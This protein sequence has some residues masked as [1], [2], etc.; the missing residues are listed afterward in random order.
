MYVSWSVFFC[1]FS[2]E[3][4]YLCLTILSLIVPVYPVNMPDLAWTRPVMAI[5]ASGQPESGRIRFAESDFP[6]PI[7]IRT[8][9]FF[10]H[11][12]WPGSSLSDP[13]L[14]IS[15]RSDIVA[16]NW[17]KPDPTCLRRNRPGPHPACL[18]WA[19]YSSIDP[20]RIRF[21]TSGPVPI[22]MGY[23]PKYEQC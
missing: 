22:S 20:N 17:T 6:H 16:L 12:K 3:C 4:F 15:T 8:G 19:G 7:R 10:R 11:R 13:F 23:P 5:S 21:C 14:Y 9:C 2:S 18:F 1:I